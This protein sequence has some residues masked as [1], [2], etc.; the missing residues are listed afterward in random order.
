MNTVFL[1]GSSR[2][3]GHSGLIAS[4][5]QEELGGDIIHLCDFNIGYFD[6]QNGNREDDFLQLV[7]TLCKYESWVL[8]T[9]VYWYSMS[10]QMKTFLDRL[11]DL[12]KWEKQIGKAIQSSSWYAIS[13]GSDDDEVPGYFEPFRRSAE[14]LDIEYL[15][16]THVWKDNRL[17]IDKKVSDR[18]QNVVRIVKAS[19]R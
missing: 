4:S 11:S 10:A 1:V 14:Y 16:N 13:C 9:P 2:K 12:L 3:S 15:G 7:T 18:I 6:Y 17:E 5:L 8:V 19:K